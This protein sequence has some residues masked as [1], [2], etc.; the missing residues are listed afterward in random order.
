[1]LPFYGNQVGNTEC[2]FAGSARTLWSLFGMELEGSSG[3]SVC[4][5]FGIFSKIG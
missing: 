2:S 5:N 1:M 3:Q 4:I